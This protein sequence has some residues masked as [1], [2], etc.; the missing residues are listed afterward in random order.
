MKK[1][2]KIATTTDSPAVNFYL[3]GGG[4]C[5]SVSGNADG[6]DLG[7][8][9]HHSYGW[10]YS[11]KLQRSGSMIIHDPIWATKAAFRLMNPGRR[12][13]KVIITIEDE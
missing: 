3:V 13:R 1:L 6:K 8:A 11:T 2:K 10:T 4:E 5:K 7:D 9:H 12:A